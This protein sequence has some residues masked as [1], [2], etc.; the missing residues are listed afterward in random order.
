MSFA[1]TSRN[2]HDGA[3]P[4]AHGQARVLRK[5]Q[6]AAAADAGDAE[7]LDRRHRRAHRAPHRRCSDGVSEGDM[8]LL[9][10][11]LARGLRCV[12][13]GDDGVKVEV[14]GV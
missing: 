14:L 13:H 1:N 12:R 10:G 2:G 11:D 3:A 4:W 9:A 7:L 8:A 5:N 6:D